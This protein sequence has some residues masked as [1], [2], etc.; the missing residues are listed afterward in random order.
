MISVITIILASAFA[1]T[2]I[3]VNDISNQPSKTTLGSVYLGNYEKEQY[4][5]VITNEV[6]AFV[7]SAIYEISYQDYIYTLPMTFFNYESELTMNGL[8]ENANN[9]AIFSMSDTNLA[10]LRSDI[11]LNFSTRVLNV[12]DIDSLVKQIKSDLGQMISLKKYKLSTYFLDSTE[13]TSLNISSMTNI[14]ASDVEAIDNA[15]DQIEILPK[16]RFSV[17]EILGPLHLTNEQYSVISTG[18]LNVL[19]KSHM[20]GFIFNTNPVMPLWATPGFNVRI[21]KVNQFDFSFFNPFEHAYQITIEKTSLTSLTFELTGVP[22]VDIYD[23]KIEVKVE[24]PFDRVY[25]ENDLLDETTI[26]IIIEE[27]E[28]EITY[29][30]LQELGLAG[31]ISYINRQITQI[32]GQVTTYKLYEE[33]HEAQ[34]SVYQRHIVEKA[35]A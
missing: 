35:G 10:E 19:S 32:N 6:N 31:D 22:Y 7:N 18:M 21:L 5:G 16:T 25:I 1:V 20:N 29:L 15:L 34:P 28:T 9:R 33:L 13:M 23:Y 17:L 2:M 24:V 11:E 12:A 8:V 14:N 30:L 26:G 3:F 4:E 27:T